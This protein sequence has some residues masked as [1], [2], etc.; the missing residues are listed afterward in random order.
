MPMTTQQKTK[1]QRQK[2]QKILWRLILSK[3][4]CTDQADLDNQQPGKV[5]SYISGVQ[6]SILSVDQNENEE[7]G[8]EQ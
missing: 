1:P 8:V 5:A 6:P 3:T 4:C 2:L 7:G